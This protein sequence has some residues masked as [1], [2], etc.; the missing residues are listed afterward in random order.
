MN[1]LHDLSKQQLIGSANF[2]LHN[3]VTK[4]NQTNTFKLVNPSR[5]NQNGEIKI[6]ATEKRADYG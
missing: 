6:Q 5:P 3:I 4:V 2:S 1:K